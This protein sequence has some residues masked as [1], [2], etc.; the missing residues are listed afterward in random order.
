[1]KK[2]FL[3][4]ALIS[5]LSGSLL[6]SHAFAAITCPATI[7]DGTAIGRSYT[8]A[9][10]DAKGGTVDTSV[11][12]NVCRMPANATPR[13]QTATS[14]QPDATADDRAGSRTTT[15]AQPSGSAAEISGNTFVPLTTIPGVGDVAGSADLPEFLNSLYMI[16]VGAAA[17]LAVLQ[18]VR[19]G[20][21]YMLGDSITEKREAKKHITMSVLVLSPAL[22]FG[23]IN[24][25][26]LDLNIDLSSLR[27]EQDNVDPT[28]QPPCLSGNCEGATGNSTTG[29]EGQEEPGQDAGDEDGGN[30]E[31][32][33]NPGYEPVP[34]LGTD[35]ETCEPVP[36]GEGDDGTGSDTIPVKLCVQRSSDGPSRYIYMG[37]MRVTPTNGS[38]AGQQCT[39]VTA[40]TED[41]TRAACQRHINGSR[42]TLVGCDAYTAGAGIERYVPSPL[43]SWSGQY[44][45]NSSNIDCE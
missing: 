44:A 28:G 38:Q 33:C 1:M 29:S 20:M 42:T 9:C 2:T 32:G 3:T 31:T 39:D 19:G 25:D 24:P 6:P 41:T 22:V 26:I 15:A 17:A 40:E 45:L 35:N 14:D 7:P 16:S 13:T 21:T 4:F 8:A 36:G 34:V 18:I 23:V 10:C 43:C 11:S 27:P 37:Y 12:P 30:P 5:I